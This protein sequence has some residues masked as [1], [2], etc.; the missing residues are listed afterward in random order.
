MQGLILDLS[1]VMR[2]TTV[3]FRAGGDANLKLYPMLLSSPA[4]PLSTDSPMRFS[5]TSKNVSDK[6]PLCFAPG[7]ATMASSFA[8]GSKQE[9]PSLTFLQGTGW[10]VLS[11]QKYPGAH[12][13]EDAGVAQKLPRS[14][15]TG[16]DD[17]T[18]QN[19]PSSSHFT[20]LLGP[21]GLKYPASQ[22]A[23]A[24]FCVEVQGDDAP[25]PAAQRAQGR[26]DVEELSLAYVPAG[27]GCC[28]RVP[29]QK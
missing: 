12:L 14:Q 2:T 19:D 4:N 7:V 8:P 3:S 13:T 22:V 18:G 6:S 1:S 27:Q 24:A 28:M 26:Q 15:V 10:T 21:P 23:Q 9:I 5:I 16:L 25:S 11:P 17:P 29:L 20:Q